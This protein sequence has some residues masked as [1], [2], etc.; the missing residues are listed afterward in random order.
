MMAQQQAFQKPSVQVQALLA[1][2]GSLPPGTLVQVGPYVVTVKRYLSQGG[3]ATVYLVT[4]EKP[5]SIPMVHGGRSEET[6]HVLKRIIVPDKETLGE[7]RREVE[8]H[9]SGGFG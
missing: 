1:P 8:V 2:P 9:V 7:V 5:L 4:S 3:F 6:V